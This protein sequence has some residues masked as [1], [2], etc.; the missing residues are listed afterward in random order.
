MVRLS[1]RVQRCCKLEHY[2]EIPGNISNT[3][4]YPINSSD[5]WHMSSSLPSQ[6]RKYLTEFSQH[7]NFPEA[8]T[9]EGICLSLS[10]ARSWMAEAWK[11]WKREVYTES[12]RRKNETSNSAFR[13]SSQLSL[14]HWIPR[15]N[16]TSKISI[17][18]RCRSVYRTLKDE[19]LAEYHSFLSPT[20]RTQSLCR[21][22][23]EAIEE[24][25]D[26]TGTLQRKF[27][28]K[29][30]PPVIQRPQAK[31]FRDEVEERRR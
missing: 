30:L 2:C 29:L 18:L 9:K 26:F 1:E 23:K 11:Y 31:L 6:M 25:I 4:H 27:P 14:H 7:F 20:P 12:E 5:S 17:P 15:L 10:F 22:T 16:L 3:L 19:S 28:S 24:N 21:R 8:I 13:F